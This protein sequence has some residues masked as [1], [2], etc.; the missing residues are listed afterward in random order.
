MGGTVLAPTQHIFGLADDAPKVR[1]IFFPRL[2]RILLPY[3]RRLWLLAP[4][5]I[6]R[7][8]KKTASICFHIHKNS[9]QHTAFSISLSFNFSR[10]VES[11]F[12]RVTQIKLSN[13]MYYDSIVLI[14]RI[15]RSTARRWTEQ[16]ENHIPRVRRI[17]SSMLIIG[18]SSAIAFSSASF[19]ASTLIQLITP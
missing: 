4:P 11:D 16:E 7:E 10:V 3:A 17:S 12:V 5:K 13:T 2:F 1:R 14:A 19:S 9:L 18:Q 15:Y 6:I 8:T